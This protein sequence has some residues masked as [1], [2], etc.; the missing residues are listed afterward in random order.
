MKSVLFNTHDLVLVITIYQCLLFAL[1]LITFKKGRRVSNNLLALFLLA[2]AAI[3][4]DILVWFGAAFHSFIEQHLPNAFFILR[5]GHW[6]EAPL[7]LFYVRSLVY[8]GPFFKKTDYLYFIPFAIALLDYIFNWF[9]LSPELKNKFLANYSL[10]TESIQ[11]RLVYLF[12][13]VFRTALGVMCLIEIRRYQ[14]HI[15]NE[16]ADVEDIDLK[17]LKLLVVGFL[18]L[19]ISAVVVSLSLISLYEFHI[20]INTEL[21]GLTGNYVFLLLL[22]LLIYFSLNSTQVFSGIEAKHEELANAPPPPTTKEIEEITLYMATQKPYLNHRLRLETF[23]K[24]TSLSPR[25][26]S[27]VIN[28]HFGKNFFEFINSYRIQ[29]SKNL[30]A[31]SSKADLTMLEV[32]AKV[33]FNSKAT[34][35]T[36][37]K[38]LVGQTPSQFRREHSK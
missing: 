16:Y 33:G 8:K 38:S 20:P 37:F 10:S 6:A 13:E 29:E 19:R 18:G 23:A 21:M 28:R 24:G 27:F 22:S 36:L 7:L 25:R 2:H 14:T 32:M 34:F 12:R 9:I 15:K 4:L 11:S 35:N 3:S 31:D 30:L 1:F 26:V 5:I 17:W